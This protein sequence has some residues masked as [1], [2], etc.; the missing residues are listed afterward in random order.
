MR[1]VKHKWKITPRG[2]KTKNYDCELCGEHA[3]AT[4]KKEADETS[5]SCEGYLKKWNRAVEI[6]KD[7]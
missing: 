1:P 2:K 5:G 4:S 7:I 6:I 3:V